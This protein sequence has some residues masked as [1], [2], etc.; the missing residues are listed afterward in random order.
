MDIKYEITKYA[1]DKNPNPHFHESHEMLIALNNEGKFF[2]RENGYQLRFGTIF[3]LPPFEI[4][5]CFC[6]GNQEYDRYVIHFPTEILK[7]MSTKSTDLVSL[8]ESA[9]VYMQLQDDVLAEVLK[10]LVYLSKPLPENPEYGAD[11]ER[12][13]CFEE[14]LIKLAK[15]ISIQGNET[16]PTL[17]CEARVNE[18]IHYIR[19]NYNHC[20]TL[21]SI[22]KEFFISKSRLSQLFKEATGFSIGDYIIT[23]RI[24]RACKL[25]KEGMQVKDASATVGF[26]TVTHFIRTFKKR[27]NC[28]PSEY[29]KSK[30]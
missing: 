5:Y 14:F 22:A 11:I 29:T 1:Q 16:L 8:F 3:I 30:E 10:A 20:I 15:V 26:H 17:E 21:E 25:L 4:H 13:I 2:V 9:P 28:S 19:K 7:K 27:M 6:H 12:N 24:K 18:I 23:Y